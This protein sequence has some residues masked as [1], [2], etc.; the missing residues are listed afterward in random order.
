VDVLLANIFS[1]DPNPPDV[2]RLDEV[3]LISFCISKISF[4][5]PLGCS[6]YPAFWFFHFTDFA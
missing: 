3:S 6:F 5:K 4:F 2:V 1:F